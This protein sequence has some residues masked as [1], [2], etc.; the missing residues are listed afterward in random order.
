MSD[1]LAH[2]GE[3]ASNAGEL[4]SLFREPDLQEQFDQTGRYLLLTLGLE[5]TQR[6]ARQR[7]S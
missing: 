7:P 1:Y 3:L 6:R 5:M 4:P 2:R